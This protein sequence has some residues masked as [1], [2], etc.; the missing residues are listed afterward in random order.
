[1]DRNYDLRKDEIDERDYK[2]ELLTQSN[3]NLPQGIDIRSLCPLVYDQ[4]KEGSCTANAGCAERVMLFGNPRLDLSRAFLY[5]EERN[6]EGTTNKDSGASIRDVCKAVKNYGIC[7]EEFMPYTDKDYRSQPSKEALINAEK[8]KINSYKSL[9]SLDDIK[10]YLYYN[11]KPVL[12]GMTVFESMESLKVAKTGELPM[13]LP[14]EPQLGEHAVLVVGYR[15]A[16]SKNLVKTFIEKF[17]WRKSQSSGYLIIRNSW[18]CS[19]GEGG[20]FYMPYEYFQ[21]YTFD[22]WV[23]E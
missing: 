13:P 23:M 9:N 17:I 3:T 10:N 4:G 6:L 19:W 8:Y 21:K 11:K 20:Y 15:D 18:G 2:L 16:D 5:Y 12:I 1:M 14:S 7:E 22:Y